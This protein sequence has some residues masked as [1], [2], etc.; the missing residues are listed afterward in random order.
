M[1]NLRHSSLETPII[2][3]NKSASDFEFAKSPLNTPLTWKPSLLFN[4]FDPNQS[5]IDSS[6]HLI[7][8]I[9]LKEKSRNDLDFFKVRAA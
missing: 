8:S 2:Q 4:R 1:D 9:Y 5:P 3:S 7:N 6:P